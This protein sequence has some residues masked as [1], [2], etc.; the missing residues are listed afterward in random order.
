MATVTKRKP[1][2]SFKDQ[3]EK[4]RADLEELSIRTIQV[5]ELRYILAQTIED[6]DSLIGSEQ[7]R[8]PILDED[9]RTM[10]KARMLQLIDKFFK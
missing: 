5:S 3:L 8:I 6:E 9:E 10:I 1:K 2:M 4:R 7:K